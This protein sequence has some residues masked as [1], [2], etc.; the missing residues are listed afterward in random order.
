[1]T[2]R[3]Q[4]SD[5]EW[6]RVTALPGLVIMAAT[7]SD[8]HLVPA[9]REIAAGAGALAEGVKRY[10]ENA[11]LRELTGKAEKVDLGSG[12]DKPTSSTEVL[13]LVTTELEASFT[14]LKAHVSTEELAQL[15]EVLTDSARAVVGRLGTGFWGSGK[16]KVS[17]DEQAFLDRLAAIFDPS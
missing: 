2:S 6:A 1:M 10:P 15:R 16:E 3:E 9:V 13:A 12:E 5:E 11:I 17:T 4:F 14:V 8:G 7:L